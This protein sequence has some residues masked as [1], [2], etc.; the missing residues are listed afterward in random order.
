MNDVPIIDYDAIGEKLRDSIPYTGTL[1]RSDRKIV[2][3]P[4][5]EPFRSAWCFG[6]VS[7]PL[8]P[9]QKRLIDTNILVYKVGVAAYGESEDGKKFESVPDPET[10]D[11]LGLPP[12]MLDDSISY[13]K[14]RRN[15]RDTSRL[16]EEKLMIDRLIDVFDFIKYKVSGDVFIFKSGDIGLTFESPSYS[17][18]GEEIKRSLVENMERIKRE[19]SNVWLIGIHTEFDYFFSTMFYGYFEDILKDNVKGGRQYVLD[20]Y[21]SILLHCLHLGERTALFTNL[22]SDYTLS[23]YCKPDEDVDPIRI[24]I[25]VGRGFDDEDIERADEIADRITKLLEDRDLAWPTGEEAAGRIVGA[26]RLLP[27][28]M[29][30]AYEKLWDKMYPG[31][32]SLLDIQYEEWGYGKETGSSSRDSESG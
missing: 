21:D 20:K 24:D 15:L 29:L 16:N 14:L 3:T 27:K 11:V 5:I 31:G 1:F 13:H 10:H 32:K 8:I 12:K 7:H 28:P 22:I 9:T 30:E 23:F 2:H 18:K 4:K 17:G 6:L 25:Y 19:V 26:N